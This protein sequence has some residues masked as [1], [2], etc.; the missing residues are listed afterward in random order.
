MHISVIIPA[1]NEEA[2]IGRVLGH[3]TRAS[4]FG[5]DIEVIVAANGCTDRTADV[6]REYGVKVVEIETPSK[7]A[8]LN[9]ADAVA[10]GFPRIYLDADIE[11]SPALIRSLARAASAPGAWAAVPRLVVDTGDSSLPVRAYYAINSRL[12]IFRGRL[13]GRGCIAVSKDARA[14]FST[15][16]DIIADD[17][18]LDAIIPADGKR[19]VQLPISVPAPRSAG[20]LVRRLARSGEGNE[21][22]WR[23]VRAEAPAEVAVDPVPGSYRWSWLWVALRRPFL[24]PAAACYATVVL[25]AARLRRSPE[26]TPRSGWGRPGATTGS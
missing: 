12:P 21:E 5:P 23:W 4:D 18:F 11:A 10:S 19:E 9:A 25:K 3:L 1:F 15:F 6:A 7:T 26:W 22:F 16:P 13:F 8:A 20:D 2:G 17:M 14:R 24:L